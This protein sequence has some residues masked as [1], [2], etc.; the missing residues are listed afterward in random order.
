M[1]EMHIVWPIAVSTLL[2]LSVLLAAP[3]EAQ[4]PGAALRQAKPFGRIAQATLAEADLPPAGDAAV[5]DS[6]APLGPLWADGAPEPAGRRTDVRLVEDRGWLCVRV[7]CAAPAGE[8]EAAR[9]ADTVI[10]HASSGGEAG[11]PFVELRFSRAGL[12]AVRVYTRPANRFKRFPLIEDV[13]PA[14][15]KSRAGETADGWQV[16]AAI[17]MSEY[18]LAPRG[19][20]G[21]VLRVGEGDEAY[22]WADL[23]GQPFHGPSQFSR[24]ALADAPAPPRLV[25][26]ARLGVGI[27]ALRFDGWT[28]GAAATL[29]GEPLSV[30]PQGQ[31][32]VEISSPGTKRIELK[33][34][35]AS[36]VYEADVPRPFLVEAAE[37]FS[38]GLA[39]PISVSVTLNAATARPARVTVRALQDGRE[40]GRAE[41]ALGAGTH[42]VEVPLTGAKAGEVRIEAEA[43]LAEMPSRPLRALHWCV[44]GAEAD[45][46]DRF[47]EG[48]GA[49][50]TRDMYRAGLADAAAFYRVLQ[51]GDGRYRAMGPNRLTTSEWFAGMCYPMA[52]LYKVDWP[53]N[54]W[55]GDRRFLESAIA[56]MD[57]GLDPAARFT[58]GRHA[59]RSRRTS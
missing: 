11:Y 59:G 57:A 25:L 2:F 26:P 10:L 9:K 47:R 3:A 31:A 40:V 53:Q 21:N 23:A 52:L 35:A 1:R 18:G 38:P 33:L 15:V 56:G 13:D 44:R 5:W 42:A 37:P 30:G 36:S 46:L 22:A 24:I 7:Q 43:V 12:A 51:A 48:V 14:T 29:N 28:A 32:D 50:S 49:L 20:A 16:T 58:A 6:A 4:E 8:S 54:P 17:P 39:G 41:A 55:R 19:F 27:N 34:N 45:S